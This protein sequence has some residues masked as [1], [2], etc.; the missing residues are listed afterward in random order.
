MPK[1]AVMDSYIPQQL[2]LLSLSNFIAYRGF[3]FGCSCFIGQ[4]YL[5]DPAFYGYALSKI[6]SYFFFFPMNF[7][8]MFDV[9][10]ALVNLSGII[11]TPV[12]HI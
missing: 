10:I 1:T 6:H 3:F 4:K 12:T 8:K 2:C 7:Q 5:I 11:Y 9:L